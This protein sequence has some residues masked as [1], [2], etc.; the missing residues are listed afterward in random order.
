MT[1]ER[2]VARLR[3]MARTPE[4]KQKV[5]EIALRLWPPGT[6]AGRREEVMRYESL[7]ADTESELRSLYEPLGVRIKVEE[8]EPY[9]PRT[10]RAP[11]RAENKW[12]VINSSTRVFYKK[13]EKYSIDWRDAYQWHYKRDAE[14]AI[15]REG[16]EGARLRAVRLKV[17]REIVGR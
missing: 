3:A 16:R 6:E 2:R 5:E 11:G 8:D 4:Q 13:P 12:V 10:T 17:A 9:Q 1:L 7:D 15:E 14:E